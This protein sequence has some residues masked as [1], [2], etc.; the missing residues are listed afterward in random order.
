MKKIKAAIAG[1]Q[2]GKALVDAG[3]LPPNTAD[4]V[5]YVPVCGVVT[6]YAMIYPGDH[7][8]L[9]KTVNDIAEAGILRTAVE[10]I[11]SEYQRERD[12]SLARQKSYDDQA[13]S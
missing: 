2:I 10:D 4:F 7:E 3:V 9:D 12:E 1:M 5:I 8:A 11:V 13:L 6:I